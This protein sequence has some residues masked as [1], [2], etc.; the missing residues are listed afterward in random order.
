MI[1]TFFLQSVHVH[2]APPLTISRQRAVTGVTM[3]SSI[4]IT[5]VLE[6]P[7]AWTFLERNLVD[8]AIVWQES[9]PLPQKSFVGQR[10][11]ASRRPIPARIFASGQKGEKICPGC[12][13]TPWNIRINISAAPARRVSIRY[14]VPR[15]VVSAE[16]FQRLNLAFVGCFLD[17]ICTG[18][19]V[20]DLRGIIGM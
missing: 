11:S 9:A 13:V 14:Y 8:D 12:P 16:Q 19:Q 1:I 6:P 3:K 2:V 20:S 17:L 5:R 4:Q 18:T 7:V 10:P 15:I